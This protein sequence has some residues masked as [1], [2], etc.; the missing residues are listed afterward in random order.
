M[1]YLLL[2]LVIGLGIGF[3]LGIILM[4]I[5]SIN[6]KNKKEDRICGEINKE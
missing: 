4:C 1:N 3:F 5:V 2:G 6:K